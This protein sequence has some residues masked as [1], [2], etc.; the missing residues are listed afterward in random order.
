MGEPT[1]T[2]AATANAEEL[3]HLLAHD[4]SFAGT[5][6]SATAANTDD[7]E[8]GDEWSRRMAQSRAAR[9]SADVTLP[10]FPPKCPMT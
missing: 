6:E 8:D 10:C 3:P 7:A 9:T 2:P 5:L 4:G 1:A